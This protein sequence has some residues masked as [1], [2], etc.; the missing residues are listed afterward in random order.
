[1]QLIQPEIDAGLLTGNQ[2]ILATKV[3]SRLNISPETLSLVSSCVFAGLVLVSTF[4]LL[5]PFLLLRA[6][7]LMWEESDFVG[8]M[9]KFDHGIPLYT[10]PADSNSMISQS[11]A[12]LLTYLIA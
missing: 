8:N 5:K 1:M 3:V 9:I 2:R 7:L 12:F 10:D 11:R 4:I 6:D